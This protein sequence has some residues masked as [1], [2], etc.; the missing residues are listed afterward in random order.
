MV[1]GASATGLAVPK[2]AGPRVLALSVC[3]LGLFFIL[4][5]GLVTPSFAHTTIAVDK[6]DVESGWDVE[7]PIVGLRNSVILSVVER[8]E[9]EG[10]STG[11]THV[12]RGVEATITFGGE[13]KVLTFNP[14]R[15]AGTL[16]GPDN[17]DQHWN[18][19]ASGA[20]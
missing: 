9:I 5:V 13:S 18:V 7:P 17:S 2:A 14:R 6:Y 1:T 8:G 19:P 3:A 20:G 10:Q 11:V 15:P 16:Q 4:S 12:F